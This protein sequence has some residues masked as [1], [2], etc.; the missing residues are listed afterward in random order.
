MIGAE[1]PVLGLRPTRSPFAANVKG[2]EGRE[3]DIIAGDDGVENLGQ[4]G[5]DEFAGLGARQADAA[6]D[7]VREIGA[8]D[9]VMRL[10]RTARCWK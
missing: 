1:A 8:C 7:G 9:G 4:H 6:M 2:A 5:F 10:S 3:L